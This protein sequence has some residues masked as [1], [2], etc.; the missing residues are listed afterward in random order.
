MA[1]QYAYDLKRVGGYDVLVALSGRAALDLLEREA[2]DCVILD[3]E[4]PGMDGFEV[5]RTMERRGLRM[6]VLVYT[7]TGNY[8]RCTEA[9][10]LG[11]RSFIDKA[12]P[13]ERVVQEVEHA[14][15][16]QRLAGQLA[17]LRGR[18]DSEAPLVGASPAMQALKDAIGRVAKIPSPVLIVGES[19]SGKELVARELHRTRD[20]RDRK[21]TRLNSS[22][23]IISYAVFCLKKKKK[24]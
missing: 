8:D 3:L 22:H 19:G 24:D 4:M 12:E 20:L 2:V 9:I 23:Q 1:E 10:R 15:E 11:A 14:L 6:P 5:L 18:L 17:V 16:Q 13:M 7:G 21:S